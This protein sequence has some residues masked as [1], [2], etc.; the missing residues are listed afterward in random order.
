MCDVV[1]SEVHRGIE[2][3]T[4]VHTSIKPGEAKILSIIHTCTLYM[5]VKEVN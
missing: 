3:C 4:M 1:M 5:Y 2:T